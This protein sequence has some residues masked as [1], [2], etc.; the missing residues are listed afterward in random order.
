MCGADED[1]LLPRL[2]GADRAM[3]S[4]L[5]MEGLVQLLKARDEVKDGCDDE[6]DDHGFAW[7]SNG[8]VVTIAHCAHGHHDEPERVK[9]VSLDVVTEDVVD[10]TNPVHVHVHVHVHE[11]VHVCMYVCMCVCACARV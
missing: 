10:D 2:L 5:D 1:E 6:Y 4:L 7:P 8:E 3:Q 9:E 11:H